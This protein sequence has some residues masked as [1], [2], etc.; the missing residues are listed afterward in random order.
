MGLHINHAS[1]ALPLVLLLLAIVFIAL[2]ATSMITNE[3]TTTEEDIQQYV[4]DAIKEFSS[5]LKIQH[6]YGQYTQQ[7]PYQLSKIAIQT[8]PLFHQEIN[9]SNWVIQ[10]Q[11]NNHM[12][13]FS[14]NYTVTSLNSSSVFSHTHWNILK[15]PYFGVLVIQDKDDS[16]LR[17]HSFSEPNDI[18]FL[19]LSVEDLLI[20]KGDYVTLYLSPGTGIEKTISFSAPLPTKQVA[21][22]W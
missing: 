2:T 19:T 1:A 10:I 9:L 15:S 4:D 20:R 3:T 21:T 8:T 6:V 11:T 22:L 16:L 5:Y 7:K 14:Y 13:I 12:N 18:A 17:Y